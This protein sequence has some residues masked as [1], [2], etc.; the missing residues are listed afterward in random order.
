MHMGLDMYAYRVVGAADHPS[1]ADDV[2]INMASLRKANHEIVE[3]YYWRK[4]ANLHGWMEQR[5][6]D[7]G[8]RDELFNCMPMRLRL[9]DI[10]V[11][12]RDVL[13][14]A[15]PETTGF[16]FGASIAKDKEDTL[17]FVAMARAAIADGDAIL[18]D[19]S[20]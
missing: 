2:H 14:D 3:L 11:L 4:H 18:Y 16:F 20:W 9:E 15:L 8:G 5:Y 10:D 6:R 13:A 12:E 1:L 19:S 7:K 17:E